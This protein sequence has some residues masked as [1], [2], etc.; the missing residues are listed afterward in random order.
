MFSLVPLV[1]LLLL[2]LLPSLRTP[3]VGAPVGAAASLLFYQNVLFLIQIVSRNTISNT[4][5]LLNN[6]PKY[7]YYLVLFGG[8][9]LKNTKIRGSRHKKAQNGKAQNH[10]ANQSQGFSAHN[11]M[12]QCRKNSGTSKC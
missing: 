8:K 7:K 10:E 4:N 2:V 11:I 6:Y 12:E 9:S 5:S 3:R 1:L